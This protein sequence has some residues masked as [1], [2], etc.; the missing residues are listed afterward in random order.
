MFT[1]TE[2]MWQRLIAQGT[3]IPATAVRTETEG[4]IQ[5]GA[6]FIIQAAGIVCPISD[7]HLIRVTGR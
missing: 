6:R 7:H 2:G 5:E 3:T 4:I 1:G